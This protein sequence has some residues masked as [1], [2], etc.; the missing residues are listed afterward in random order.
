MNGAAVEACAA[1]RP[2]LKTATR[3]A[4]PISNTNETLCF[5]ISSYSTT[6]WQASER[7]FFYRT[8]MLEICELTPFR[9]MTTGCEPV[10]MFGG[11]T[12]FT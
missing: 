10:E 9:V 11:T 1:A 4:E 2:A 8:T 12:T 6:G 5:A 3:A 7:E